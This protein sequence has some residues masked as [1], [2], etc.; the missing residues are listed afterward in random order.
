[1]TRTKI[2]QIIEDGFKG[3]PYPGDD[4]LA[5][6]AVVAN[7]ACRDECDYVA[8]YF[9]GK[10]C[11]DVTLE[12]LHAHYEGPITACL[13]FMSPEAFRYYLPAFMRMAI[14][15]G[16]WAADFAETTTFALT[17]PHYDP[18]L[19]A[20]PPRET[21]EALARRLEWWKICVSVFSMAE[22]KAILAY[23]NYLADQLEGP[24]REICFPKEALAYW[25]DRTGK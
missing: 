1:M 22:G 11:K 18:R 16:E 4:K 12:D 7:A 10:S 25:A 20:I 6:R 8:A 14:S 17:P 3:A 23:L 5:Y 21:S 15:E 9:K 2:L 24:D 13:S 19:E